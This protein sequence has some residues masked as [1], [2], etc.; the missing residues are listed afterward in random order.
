[1]ASEWQ[2]HSCTFSHAFPG[3]RCSMCDKLRTTTQDMADFV[4]GKTIRK[5]TTTNPATS[6]SSSSSNDKP[7]ND[8]VPRDNNRV[9]GSGPVV[10][11]N[12]DSNNL[13]VKSVP[14]ALIQKNKGNGNSSTS[15]NN[16]SDRQPTIVNPYLKS[17]HSNKNH[18]TSNMQNSNN[19]T[20]QQ[21]SNL[22]I[23]RSNA[24]PKVQSQQQTNV[25]SGNTMN[26]QFIQSA[27]PPINLNQKKP[28]NQIGATNNRT[29]N[30][31]AK[32]ASSRQQ[33]TTAVQN[34]L[35]NTKT[36]VNNNQFRHQARNHDR[37]TS[38]VDDN[39]AKISTWPHN[40]INPLTS[41]T[42]A[43]S[44]SNF[45]SN[46]ALQNTTTTA[47]NRNQIRLK[48]RDVNPPIPS[49]RSGNIQQK[50]TNPAT[51]DSAQQRLQS[52]G[53]RGRST[54]KDAEK[55]YEP[56]PVP[57]ATGNL[58]K[59]W[60]YPKS[61]KYAEREYQL[62]ISRSCL[63]ENT[64]VSLPTGLGK[65]L[66]AAVVMYNFYRWFPTGKIVFLAPTRPL[67]RQQIEA[68]YNIMGIPEVHTAEISGNVKNRERLWRMRRVFFCTPQAF[69]RDIENGLCDI[70]MVVCLVLDEAHKTT[71]KYA[72]NNVVQRLQ[73]AGVKARIVSG[74]VC[75]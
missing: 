56:G 25:T 73:D 11:L 27:T 24:R 2:C 14:K 75:D 12:A 42:S 28:Q 63:L 65:T 34:T 44:N 35:T 31:Y 29:V 36:S 17:S 41:N 45:N 30:P 51:T 67:V 66:I 64:L 15:S 4:T 1:M 6:S 39:I 49:D 13:P 21:T 52:L 43:D 61:E 20:S 69:E 3:T 16:K 72:Y 54:A 10:Q 70:G 32:N 53:F 19:R 57:L 50:G 47:F 38:I 7:S 48:E 71:K 58:H 18:S 33:E 22:S 23:A 59:T 9:A 55:I 8:G 5:D 74:N 62:A 68:C 40:G 60:I 37:S 26:S 46:T